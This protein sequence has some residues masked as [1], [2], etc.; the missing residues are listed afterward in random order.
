MNSSFH[1]PAMEQPAPKGALA[2]LRYGDELP[3]TKPRSTVEHPAVVTAIKVLLSLGSPTAILRAVVAVI[4]D[5]VETGAGERLGTHITKEGLEGLPSRTNT[6]P[7]PPIPV[8]EVPL[9]V[10]APG[11]HPKPRRILRSFL[12]DTGDSRNRMPMSAVPRNVHRPFVAPAR[13]NIPVEDTVEPDRFSRSA[14]A[15]AVGKNILPLPL[16]LVEDSLNE[17]LAKPLPYEGEMVDRVLLS[18]PRHNGLLH[19]PHKIKTV[20]P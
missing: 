16:I 3:N 15:G 12:F 10:G 1:F 17:E 13:L 20:K 7:P 9:C 11:V 2:D 14:H 4:V 6:N 5:P 8:P 19:I 18:V